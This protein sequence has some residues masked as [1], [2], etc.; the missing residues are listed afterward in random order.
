MFRLIIIALSLATAVLFAAPRIID[1]YNQRL[2]QVQVRQ[3]SQELDMSSEQ[4]VLPTENTMPSIVDDDDD[5]GMVEA[6]EEE[7]LSTIT[8][9]EPMLPNA[10]PVERLVAAEAI[11]R[12]Q[13]ADPQTKG[14]AYL[15]LGSRYIEDGEHEKAEISFERALEN[16]ETLPDS[17]EVRAQK[18]HIY[19][20]RAKAHREEGNEAAW[21]E[22]L[23]Q[24]CTLQ[25]SVDPQCETIK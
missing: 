25:P 20:E 16:L 17:P 19:V 13:T 21:R 14:S 11:V 9:I 3:M 2:Q 23:R 10:S 7:G 8:D 1:I 12:E 5:V 24:A 22:D 18:A 4:I 15:E 6:A